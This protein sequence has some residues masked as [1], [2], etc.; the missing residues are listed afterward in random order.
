MRQ[1][2][3][4]IPP[5]LKGMYTA[6]DLLAPA[7]EALVVPRRAIHEGRIYLAD[8]DDR[9]EIRPVDI[10]LT[11]GELAVVRGGLEPGE[12]VIVT[13]LV[14]VIEGMPLSVSPALDAEQDLRRRALGEAP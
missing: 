4:M 8:A 6:V 3:R 13:D 14:P 5:L 9:L 7:R 2:L 10:Q 12:R 1:T 11:Q